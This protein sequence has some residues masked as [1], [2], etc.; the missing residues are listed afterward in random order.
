MARSEPLS[1]ATRDMQGPQNMRTQD[2][3]VCGTIASRT[4]YVLFI[5]L[6]VRAL[7]YVNAHAILRTSMGCWI[8]TQSHLEL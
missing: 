4:S 6:N 1:P 8:L 2:R 5:R 7:V 3:G